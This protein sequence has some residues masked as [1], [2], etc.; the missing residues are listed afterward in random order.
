MLY[1]PLPTRKPRRAQRWADILLESLTLQ[2]MHTGYEAGII[3]VRG[4]TRVQFIVRSGSQ[5]NNGPQ[6]LVND[7]QTTVSFLT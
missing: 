7:T 4:D 2:V 6:L 3:A 5:I 1:C